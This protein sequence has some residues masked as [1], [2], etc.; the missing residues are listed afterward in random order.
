MFGRIWLCGLG[1]ALAVSAAHA[2]SVVGDPKN[3]AKTFASYCSACHKS[4]QGLAKGGSVEGF[5]RQHYTTGPEMS[6]AMAAY[7]ASAGPGP[8]AR[9]PRTTIAAG[10]RRAPAGAGKAGNAQV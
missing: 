6:A 8:Q 7:L 5:L 4:P 10:H 9:Q 3:P 2:Q 1:M